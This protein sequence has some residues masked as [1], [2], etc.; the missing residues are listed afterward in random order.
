M[1]L[2]ALA[3]PDEQLVLGAGIGEERLDEGGLAG[4]GLAAHQH[5][6]RLAPEG[7]AEVLAEGRELG[8]AADDRGLRAGG[9][10]RDALRC[11]R[12][13]RRRGEPRVLLEDPSLEIPERRRRVDAELLGQGAPGLLVGREGFRL[14]VAAVEGEHELAARTLAQRLARDQR[15]DLAHGRG[16][17]SERELGL[18]PLLHEGELE[19]LEAARLG[20]GE[21]L[22]ELRERRP[23]PQGDGI[24]EKLR[25]GPAVTRREGVPAPTQ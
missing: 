9:G 4:A 21:G 23:A 20:G 11:R 12:R 15:L 24:R 8:R 13:G 6:A 1:L 17:A 19:L 16:V 18:D 7:G 10:G 2:D 22:V 25:G 14:A 3:A 5:E